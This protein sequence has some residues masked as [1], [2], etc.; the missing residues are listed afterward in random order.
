MEKTELKKQ[1][2][3]L[4]QDVTFEYHG[5]SACINPWAEDKF[6]VGFGDVERTYTNIKELME[7]PLY[8]GESLSKICSDLKI[9]LV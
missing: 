2:M 5:K 9:E 8:D 7:D 4:T 1:I 3:S 6:Q